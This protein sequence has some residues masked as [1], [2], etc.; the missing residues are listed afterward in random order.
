MQSVMVYCF[1][2]IMITCR[3]NDYIYYTDVDTRSSDSVHPVSALTAM[4]DT[5]TY[6]SIT[7]QI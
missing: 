3:T 4:E 5:N 7:E 2:L 6:E 1:L